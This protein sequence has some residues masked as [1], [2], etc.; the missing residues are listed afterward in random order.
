M[1]RGD[2]ETRGSRPTWRIMSD[3]R[4]GKGESAQGRRWKE[5]R[6]GTL[7]A[8]LLR[9]RFFRSSLPLPLPR[10]SFAASFLS[11]RCTGFCPFAFRSDRVAAARMLLV[12]FAF[13]G[14]AVP[15]NAVSLYIH[16]HGMHVGVPGNA[17]MWVI[18]QKRI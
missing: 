15:I 3:D 17:G 4:V 10:R 1:L 12:L 16:D 11:F 18:A 5:K 2:P 9:F 6:S 14:A 8:G 13:C 7:T